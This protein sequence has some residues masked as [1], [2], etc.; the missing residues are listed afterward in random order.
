MLARTLV[1]SICYTD[2]LHMPLKLSHVAGFKL[3]E[4]GVL[5]SGLRGENAAIEP[6]D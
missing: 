6:Y 5:D 4:L 1:L 2:V 3:P